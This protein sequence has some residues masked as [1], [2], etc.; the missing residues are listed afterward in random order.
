MVRST[1][2]FVVCEL[3]LLLS[4]V[5]GDWT[6]GPFTRLEEDNPVLVT[7]PETRFYCPLQKRQIAWESKDVFNP[8]AVVRDGKVHLLYRAE[9]HDGNLAGTSRIG[10]AVSDDG[11]SFPLSQRRST[12]VFYP[13]QD[14]FTTM[15]VGSP[16][17]LSKIRVHYFF[18]LLI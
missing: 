14:E 8:S 3:F 13:D 6:L 12:P 16:P 10:L 7:R 9:D 5:Q 1:H 15:E 2:L 11:V 4:D 17:P 18:Y